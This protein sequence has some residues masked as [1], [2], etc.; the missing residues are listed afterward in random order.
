MLTSL[1]LPGGLVIGILGFHCHGPGSVSGQGTEM[2]LQALLH[3]HIYIYVYACVHAKSLQ[4]CTT[5]CNPMDYS[6]QGSLS[7][8]FF[9]QE[10]WR[11]LPC[12]STG[13]L[14]NPGRE[15]LSLTSPILAGR[16]FITSTTWE[17]MYIYTIYICIC[18]HIYTYVYT[19][20][21]I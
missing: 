3:S 18:T 5:L 16:F 2:I 20:T 19:H 1:E 14:P 13:D 17:A 4:S 8:G 15:P 10:Y 11:E 6:L 9:R 12:P 7:M 21:H